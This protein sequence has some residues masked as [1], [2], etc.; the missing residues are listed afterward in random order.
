MIRSIVVVAGGTGGH[1]MPALALARHL[2]AQGQKIIFYTDPRGV[3]YLSPSQEPFDIVVMPLQSRQNVLKFIFSIGQCCYQALKHI[4][5]DRLLGVIS[6]GGYSAFAW[7]LMAGLYSVPLMLHEQ[8][9]LRGRTNRILAF[10]AQHVALTFKS[11]SSKR[12]WLSKIYRPETVTGLP[13]RSEFTAQNYQLPQ[14]GQPF[15]LLVIGGSQGAKFL[16]E[17]VP[18]AI[19]LLSEDLRQHIK[20]EQQCASDQIENV[21]KIYD[22]AQVT[23]SLKPF[24]DPLAQYMTEAHLI[25]AR[26]GA[27]T[28]A[29]IATIGRPAILVPY[30]YAQDDHQTIN[31]KVFTEHHRGWFFDQKSLTFEKLANFLEN[32]LKNPQLLLS[33]VEAGRDQSHGQ[34]TK[35]LSSL[36]LKNFLPEREK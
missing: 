20:V 33:V 9:A 13:L 5:K 2:Y 26:A 14:S 18:Q 19:L 22:Q 25:I 1:V 6:F 35:M 32:I 34:A 28:L 29:E 3:Q 21:Q 7:G 12:N 16:N 10:W 11:K 30:P 24:F 8:N 36:V 27:S 17:V 4:L 23:V 31:A 15:Q